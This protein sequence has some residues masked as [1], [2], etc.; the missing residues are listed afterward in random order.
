MRGLILAILLFPC[1]G[2]AETPQ[3]FKQSDNPDQ[4]KEINRIIERVSDPN[5]RQI[6]VGTFA[7]STSTGNQSVTGVGFRPRLVRLYY[8][9]GSAAQFQFSFGSTTANNQIAWGAQSNDLDSGGYSVVSTTSC[10]V[11]TNGAGTTIAQ[12]VFVS[13]DSD[14]FTINWTTAD[15]SSRTIGYEALQ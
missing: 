12:A 2:L 7:S 13:M 4:A 6:K 5:Y 1:A 8:G 3:Y 9:I 14:G 11:Y 10:L 15:S